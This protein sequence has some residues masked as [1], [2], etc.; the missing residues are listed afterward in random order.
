MWMLTDDCEIV[1][2]VTGNKIQVGRKSN[3]FYIYLKIGD[4]DINVLTQGLTED[5]LHEI[6]KNLMH[7]INCI[8][9][10]G[11]TYRERKAESEDSSDTN[12]TKRS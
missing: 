6:M 7:S 11:K 10:D 4:D 9:P 3:D 8:M 12:I 5:R 2:S 1:H